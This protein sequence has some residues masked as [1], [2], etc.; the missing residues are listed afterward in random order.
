MLL[1]TAVSPYGPE[2]VRVAFMSSL[3]WVGQDLYVGVMGDK[4]EKAG[5]DR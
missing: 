4:I 1:F 5:K 3:M 2:K